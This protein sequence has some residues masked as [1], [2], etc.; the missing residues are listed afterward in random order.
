MSNEEKL[1]KLPKNCVYFDAKFDPHAR[2]IGDRCWL[3]RDDEPHRGWIK[4]ICGGEQC[5][6]PC[7]A[8]VHKNDPML[9][10]PIC[11]EKVDLM[12]DDFRAAKSN[13]GHKKC[14]DSIK[15]VVEALI[16]PLQLLATTLAEA[17]KGLTIEQLLIVNQAY[18]SEIIEEKD[19]KIK[20][21]EEDLAHYK[22]FFEK[23]K[24]LKDDLTSKPS[25]MKWGSLYGYAIELGLI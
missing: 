12:R 11:K 5:V 9:I 25:G 20:E 10:C 1:E 7:S 17:Y 23:F 8:F 15:A 13:M 24:E 21:L 4:Y 6:C 22:L 18:Q 3:K 14:I 19:L 2:W 16:P